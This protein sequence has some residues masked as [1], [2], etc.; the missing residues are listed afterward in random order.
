MNLVKK[1]ILASSAIA[2]TLSPAYA[3]S[4]SDSQKQDLHQIIH[5]YLTDN[6]EVLMEASQAYK[7]KQMQQ[8]RDKANTF[9]RA[10]KKQFFQDHK[11]P[12][13]GN[14]HGDITL[15][16]F[17]DYQC[18][19]CK[20]MAGTVHEL[21]Q[22]D[23]NIRLVFKQ[24]P[25]FKG[26]SLTAAKAALAANNQGKFLSFHD[27]L[28]AEK[29]PLTDKNIYAIAAQVGLN[30]KKLKHDMNSSEVTR[31]IEANTQLAQEFLQGTVGY[32]FTPIFVVGNQS[33]SKF[34]FI[35]GGLDLPG[36]QKVISGLRA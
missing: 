21:I 36:L 29:K 15:V 26:G 28:M 2:L 13:A 17:F 18:G 27:A 9:I 11:A 22:N 30:V 4:F 1:L 10:H 23:K 31:Q 24:L 5:Q 7:A 3:S 25:I 19:H 16:E 33:G 35:P 14:A 20:Q 6:P 12:T 34:Q 8:M 32:V